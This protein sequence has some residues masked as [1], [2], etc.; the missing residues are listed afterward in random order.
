M[1][2]EDTL[3]EVVE[4]L[5]DYTEMI[6]GLFEEF[7]GTEDKRVRDSG[8]HLKVGPYGLNYING[9]CKSEVIHYSN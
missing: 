8:A 3:M 7:D 4:F 2:G 5:V 6:F 9:S 1:V